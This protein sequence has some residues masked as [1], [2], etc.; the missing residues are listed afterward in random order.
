[1]KVFAFAL[2]LYAGAAGASG[3]ID[4]VLQQQ[5]AL[6]AGTAARPNTPHP[7][8][9]ARHDTQELTQRV[10][11]GVTARATGQVSSEKRARLDQQVLSQRVLLGSRERG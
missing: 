6:L 8:A 9:T 5:R 4:G 11:L 3:S 10:L 1:M 2:L 7:I